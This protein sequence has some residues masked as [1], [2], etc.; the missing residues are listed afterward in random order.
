MDRSR[1]HLLNRNGPD[2]KVDVWTFADKCNFAIQSVL[3]VLV[4]VFFVLFC[5]YASLYGNTATSKQIS[6]SSP[7]PPPPQSSDLFSVATSNSPPPPKKSDLISVTT[8][9]GQLSGTNGHGILL[10]SNADIWIFEDRPYRNGMYINGSLFESILEGTILTSSYPNAIVSYQ[11]ND[12]LKQFELE[13][14]NMTIE[15][16]VIKIDWISRFETQQMYQTGMMSLFIDNIQLMPCQCN[17]WCHFSCGCYAASQ[18]KSSFF[19]VHVDFS[20]MG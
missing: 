3:C 4:S 15:G 9:N 5:V 14:A 2:D 18:C 17:W 11:D 7:P 1:S 20:Y 13:T 10:M 19:G 6:A 12:R 16:S 8:Q